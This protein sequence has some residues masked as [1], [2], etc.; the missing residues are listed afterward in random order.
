MRRAKTSN[1]N[2]TCDTI[3]TVTPDADKPEQMEGF[4]FAFCTTDAPV[5][6]VNIGHLHS[7]DGKVKGDIHTN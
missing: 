2:A 3:S 6:G 4:E 7:Q 5:E 1:V